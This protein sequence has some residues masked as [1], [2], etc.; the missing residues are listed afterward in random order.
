[1]KSYEFI[2]E[3]VDPDHEILEE[4]LKEKAAAVVL[5]LGLLGP[6]AAQNAEAIDLEAVYKALPMVTDVL[7]QVKGRDSKEVAAKTAVRAIE[8]HRAQERAY[9]RN[10]ANQIED[11][12][13]RRAFVYAS[14]Q[15]E[16]WQHRVMQMQSKADAGKAAAA[17]TYY[18]KVRSHYADKYGI[19]LP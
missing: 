14:Q 16:Q 13:D 5:A 18:K 17:V 9:D 3:Y 7:T 11:L 12:R 4:G 1:M 10:F 19:A 6:F 15:K 2:V 8:E